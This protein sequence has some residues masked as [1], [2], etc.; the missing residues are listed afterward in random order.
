MSEWIRVEGGKYNLPRKEILRGVEVNVF[1][2][3]YDVPQGVRGEFDEKLNRFQ[4][5][6]EYISEEGEV[7]EKIDKRWRQN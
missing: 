5:T 7:I 1:M 4:I 6:F 3:P 2:S